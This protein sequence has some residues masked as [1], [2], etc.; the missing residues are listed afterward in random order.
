MS[1]RSVARFYSRVASA[2]LLWGCL[3]SAATAADPKWTEWG[4]PLPY[5][6][7]SDKS[8]QW[9][10]SKGWWPL[11]YGYSSTWVGE[12]TAPMLISA[13]KLAEARGL[14]IE[15]RPF[16]AGPPQNEG[17]I[18]GALQVANGG[19]LPITTLVS[20]KA[21]VRSVGMI[22]TAVQEVQ[23]MV[24]LASTMQKPT[25]LKG[26]TVGVVIGSSG[27]FGI[28]QYAIG[29]G[30]QPGKD[31]T[32]TS[33]PIPDQMTLPAGI[34]AV[35]PWCPTPRMMA[36]YLKN[37]RYFADTGEYYFGWG[38]LHVR[39]ELIQNVPDVVQ[40]IVDM[41]I[42]AL[43]W[44]RLY[45]DKAVDIMVSEPALK[46]YPRALLAEENDVWVNHMKPTFFYPFVDVYATAG[47]TVAKWLHVNGRIKD[48]ATEDSYRAY[49]KDA[50]TLVNR[51]YEKLGW[52]IPK[53]PPYLPKG[54]TVKE[55]QAMVLA[56]KPLNLIRPYTL[57]APQ[58][59]PEPSDLVRPWYFAGK[60]YKPAQN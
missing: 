50:P 26:K 41:N 57:E 51:T 24:P 23:I 37:A 32:V 15:M 16:L 19:E 27:E 2:L 53:D 12:F 56:G 34:D 38:S 14:A 43:L 58:P 36:K 60:T 55:L 29:H 4:W 17:I 10:K 48:L 11:T 13:N 7:V 52:K 1:T 46:G 45:P 30:L 35:A 20:R 39:E 21:P 44:S 49:F 33:M 28:V 25:D 8:V 6:K 3:T 31:F 18:S 40:A 59:W 9:L 42:E 5:E 54:T 47:L 22:W